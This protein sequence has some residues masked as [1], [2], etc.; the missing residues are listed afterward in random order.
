MAKYALDSVVIDEEIARVYRLRR[1]QEERIEEDE[2]TQ[3]L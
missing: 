2:E 1:E 3:G